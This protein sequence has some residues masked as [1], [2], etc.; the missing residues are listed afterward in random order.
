MTLI[1]LVVSIAVIGLL[2]TAISAAITVTLRQQPATTAR[3][4]LAR[5]E[6]N[7]GTWLPT[8]LASASTA[9]IDATTSPCA[10]ADCTFGANAL[11]LAWPEGSGTTTV[12]Y[13]YGSSDGGSTYELRRVECPAAGSCN[14]IVVV[15]DLA[16]PPD[17]GW[18]AADGAPDT[19]IRISLPLSADSTS[20]GDTPLEN[21]RGRRF[22]ITVGGDDPTELAYSGGGAE[23]VD[24][25]PGAISPPSF[26]Q[27]A[28]SCGGP[29]TLI[30][31]ESLSIG[32]DVSKV[33]TGVRS[34]V[35][36]F[37]GTPTKLQL[38]G[39]GTTARAIGATSGEWNK[40][41]DLSEPSDVALLQ[42]NGSTTGV[43]AGIRNDGY[44][45][46]EDAFNR[47][48]YAQDGQTYQAIGN[49]AYPEPELVVFFTDGLPTRDR[50]TNRTGL[51]TGPSSLPSRFNGT[52][53]PFGFSP[54]GWYRTDWVVR[55]SAIRVIGVGVGPSFGSSQNLSSATT[56]NSG[57]ISQWAA[58]GNNVPAELLLGD[59]IAGQDPT[60]YSNSTAGRYVKSVYSAS[61]G[62]SDVKTADVLVTTDFSQFG[63]ALEQIPLEECGGTLTVQTRDITASPTPAPAQFDVTYEV[64]GVQ[65]KTSRVAKTGTWDIDLGTSASAT[66]DLIPTP[67][68][69]D[70]SGFVAD[71]WQCRAKGTTIGSDPYPTIVVGDVLSGVSIPVSAAA[72]VSCTLFV[73][74]A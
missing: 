63:G 57:R 21:A 25:E 61:T 39:M 66:V 7:L 50:S 68:A 11:Q 12:S 53:R 36:A 73:R 67:G 2:V 62:W 1:E 22:V 60:T 6:Q 35:A 32:A 56:L 19:V 65:S 33:K 41:Y 27:A 52:D 8:D 44:T 26:L 13:R 4:E 49:P 17:P 71:H 3:I 70:G 23:F 29:I 58:S 24:L 14:S 28:S 64:D 10:T 40:V 15:R 54:R 38:I 69:L 20:S 18:V 30:V 31:D 74:P 45:N 46:W 9:N 5:W 72:A 37:D 34:F 59:L 51:Q 48:F 55:Q 42:G 16:A 47:A 43:I